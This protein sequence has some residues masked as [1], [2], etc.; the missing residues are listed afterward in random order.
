MRRKSARVSS[1]ARARAQAPRFW[2]STHEY[3]WARWAHEV[4]DVDTPWAGPKATQRSFAP[5]NKVHNVDLHD[6]IYYNPGRPQLSIS[7]L[8]SPGMYHM[9]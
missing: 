2:P 5:K 1:V 9:S 8:H 3:R 7:R 6:V 4:A